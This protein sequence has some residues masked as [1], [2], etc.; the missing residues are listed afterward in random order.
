MQRTLD[1]TTDNDD[2]IDT[3]LGLLDDC[4]TPS[5]FQEF[6]RR[7]SNLTY[8]DEELE[9]LSDQLSDWLNQRIQN[10]CDDGAEVCDSNCDCTTCQRERPCECGHPDCDVVGGS[11]FRVMPEDE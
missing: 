4:L 9:E 6:V 11:C 2:Y 1:Q 3:V 10:D 5:N 7:R 8:S